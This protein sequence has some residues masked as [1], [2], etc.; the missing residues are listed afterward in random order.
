MA[1]ED[2]RYRS[3]ERSWE[4]LMRFICSDTW[5]H[6]SDRGTTVKQGECRA[7]FIKEMRRRDLCQY[8]HSAALLCNLCAWERPIERG[9]TEVSAWWHVLESGVKI[10][11]PASNIQEHIKEIGGTP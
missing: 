10:W 6:A 11:C 5:D 7:C 4:Q 8:R 9:D 1:L 2:R 3:P